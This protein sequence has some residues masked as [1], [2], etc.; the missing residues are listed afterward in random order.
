MKHWVQING[1]KLTDTE[2]HTWK[3]IALGCPTKEIAAQLGMTE[4]AVL[5][6]RK[7]LYRKLGINCSAKATTEA[8]R[9]GV[10]AVEVL[11]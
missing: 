4:N 9:H 11:K 5:S 10:I 7:G 1:Y 6:Y 3:S 8:I 2:F